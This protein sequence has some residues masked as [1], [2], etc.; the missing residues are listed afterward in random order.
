M[1]KI[2]VSGASGLVGSR[3]T[4]LLSDD[5]SFI[6]LSQRMVDITKKDQ[7]E[8]FF[9]DNQF[10]FF[11]HLAAYTNVDGA[12]V[13]KEKA[14]AIN[15]EGTKN[16]FEQS[17]A[18]KINFI[19]ISTDFVFDGKNP[20]FDEESKPNPISYYGL[21]KYQGEE[22][23]GDEGM[24]VR[25]AYPYRTQFEPKKDFVRTIY[26][27]LRENKQLTMVENALMTPTFIDDIAYGLKYL[28]NHYSKQIFHLVGS[29][30]LSP[31]EAGKLIAQKFNLSEDLISPI[32]YGEYFKNKAK[33]PQFSQIVSKKNHF[34]P[35][36]SFEEGL[37]Q[38][39]KMMI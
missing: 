10:D 33:R 11:L 9:Q 35:M 5:F 13:E 36:A 6:P 32:S 7:V 21:T 38:I 16:V 39:V 19:Y 26:H 34:H 2:A 37:N 4:E 18:K 12:E 3:I 23:I 22:I 15:V 8:Q 31:Y 14:Y 17:V 20:P 1:F 30:S 28:I 29:Q 25:I 27:L 24:I